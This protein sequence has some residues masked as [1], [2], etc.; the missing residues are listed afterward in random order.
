M[1]RI[2]AIGDIHVAADTAGRLRAGLSRVNDEVDVLLVAGDLTKCGTTAEADLVADELAEV[3]V[4]VLA[5]L[6]NHDHHDGR[7]ADVAERLG[8]R[9][10]RVLEGDEAVLSVAGCRLGVAG[11]KGFGGG[12]AGASATEFGEAE[13]KAFVRHS[14]EVAEQLAAALGRLAALGCDRRVALT[15]Y[16]PVP[17]TLLGERLELYP[18]LGS[19]HLGEAID[20]AEAD[21]AVHGHAHGGTERGR[22]P[23]GI[24]VRNVAM[25]VVRCAYRVF[26]LAVPLPPATQHH[27][28]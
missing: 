21:L 15:H 17:D 16:A 14:I 9:G 12:F 2:G 3:A 8:R 4:P 10:I 25:P 23:A 24:P 5:V 18:F 13:T 11:V 6:G 7:P 26:E 19:Q 20:D 1:I 22:T 28:D 27:A